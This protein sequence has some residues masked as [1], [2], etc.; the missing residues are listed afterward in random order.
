MAKSWVTVLSFLSHTM[1]FIVSQRYRLEE[2]NAAMV[3]LGG[4]VWPILR[5]AVR[6]AFSLLL[7]DPHGRRGTVR[8]FTTIA[9]DLPVLICLNAQDSIEVVW[10]LVICLSLV[11]AVA[12]ACFSAAGMGG[13]FSRSNLLWVSFISLSFT[14]TLKGPKGLTTGEVMQRVWFSVFYLAT[15][16]FLPALLHRSRTPTPAASDLESLAA[17]RQESWFP[18]LHPEKADVPVDADLDFSEEAIPAS[19]HVLELVTVVAQ[20]DSV[21]FSLWGIYHAMFSAS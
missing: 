14:L 7:M 10:V 1:L 21:C 9:L 3:F 16:T 2:H 12:A 4:L 8:V 5:H 13:M 17:E 20:A 19:R 15:V 6:W 11:D 18:T